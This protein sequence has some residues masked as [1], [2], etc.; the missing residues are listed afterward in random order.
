MSRLFK[1]QFVFWRRYDFLRT[2]EGYK[3]N[4]KGILHR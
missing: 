3:D 1:S 2:L 4:E